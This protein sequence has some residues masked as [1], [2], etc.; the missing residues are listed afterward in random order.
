MFSSGF[1][2]GTFMLLFGISLLPIF[3][4][5]IKLNIKHIQIIL[6]IILIL[7]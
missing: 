7:L 1:I 3:Y 2:A 6:P 4:E 5:K